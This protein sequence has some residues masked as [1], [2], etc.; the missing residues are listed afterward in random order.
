MR[1]KKKEL[2]GEQLLKEAYNT[3]M[4]DLDYL[5]GRKSTLGI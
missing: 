4:F 3:I 1:F 5:F 2:I